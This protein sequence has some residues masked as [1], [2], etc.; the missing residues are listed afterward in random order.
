MAVAEP[1]RRRLQE[2]LVHS[3]GPDPAD[4]LMGY[5]PPTGR[6]EQAFLR[7]DGPHRHHGDAQAQSIQR[8]E[9]APEGPTDPGRGSAAATSWAPRFVQ[10]R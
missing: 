5:L 4:T 10:I 1:S 2:A 3:T 6:A 9:S 8:F 7:L